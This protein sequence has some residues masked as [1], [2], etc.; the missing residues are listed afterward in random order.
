MDLTRRTLALSS[1][2]AA[3][4]AALPA[5]ALAGDAASGASSG[6]AWDL[7]DLYPNDGAWDAEQAAVRKTFPQLMALKGT[8]GA[9]AQALKA[10]LDAIYDANERIDRLGVYAGLKADADTS[11]SASVER[12]QLAIALGADFGEA[13][14]WLNP[15]VLALG[16]DKVTAFEA[17]EPGL[18]KFRFPLA[19]ILRQAP[20]TLG[21]EAEGVLAA[22]ADPLSGPDQFRSQLVSADIPWP[23]LTLASGPITLDEQGYE[24]AREAP[25]RAERKQ[26]FDTFWGAYA[27]YK[28][29]LAAAL[30]SLVQGHI[31]QAK[32]RHYDNS[33]ASALSGDNVPEGVYRTLVAET[34][35][36]LP[37]L[38]RYF[39]VRQKLLGLPDLH[40]YDIYPPPTRID[41]KF[42]LAD[43]R[44]LTLAAVRPLGKDYVDTLAKATAGRWM[45]PSPRKNKASGAYMN[46]SAYAVHPYLLLN[47]T[48]NYESLSTFAHEWGHAMHSVLANRVQPYATS[49]YST[50]I[51]EIA[52]T[53]NEQLLAAYM[54]A[55]AKTKAEKLFYLDALLDLLRGTFFRQAMFAEFELA[56]HEAAERGE[57]L[58]ADRLTSMYLKLL[59]DYH[60]DAVIIDEPYAIEWAYVPHFYYNFYVYQYATS[61]AASAYFSERTIGGDP[62]VVDNY[63][64]VLRAGGSDYPVEILK[65][66]GLD[67]TAPAPYRALVAKF[68]RTL[69]EIEKVMAS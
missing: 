34:R 21:S 8:L 47:L 24:A 20:H 61:I 53:H 26:V 40:Y 66:A 62:K 64:S 3:S 18:A 10:A 42:S 49:S 16:A 43:D 45:D 11:V 69:D 15:E 55:G 31:F 2:A 12:R 17:A 30:S 52:S 48:D 36:G 65:R 46:G 57:G 33:L 22:A 63:L 67:M 58:S 29:S 19:N 4:A 41:R 9:S 25:D 1:L 13:T 5:A 27:T 56:I 51:A 59:R 68:T 50:F 38:H 39:R 14:A 32:A 28:T 37:A 7:T 60:G 6:A 35:A 44:S 54:Y 23:K